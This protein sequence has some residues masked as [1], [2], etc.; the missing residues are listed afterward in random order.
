VDEETRNDG[1][2]EDGM[3]TTKQSTARHGEEMTQPTHSGTKTKVQQS[4]GDQSRRD[5]EATGTV[6][7][8]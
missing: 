3:K 8:W 1:K 2:L 6:R 5:Q 4:S 7:A